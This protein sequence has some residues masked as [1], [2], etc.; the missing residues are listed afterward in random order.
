MDKK[1]H[2]ITGLPRSGSTLLVSILR[3][4]PR[5]SSSISDSLCP[6][7]RTTIDN[8]Q[9]GPGVKYEVPVERRRNIAKYLIN[10]FYHDIDKP[11]IFNTSRGWTLITNV[12]KDILP[13]SKLIVCVRDINWIL[14]SFE[15]AQ[16]RN[17]F[18]TS[19]VSGG[20]QGN[21]Y[22]RC[23]MLMEDNGVVGA[24][25]IGVKQ[26]IS[27][28]EKNL[29]F[30]LEYNELTKNPE[31]TIRS[32]YEFIGEPYFDHDF[33]NVEGS[34]DEYDTEIGIKLHTVRKKVQYIEREHI[35]PPDILDRYR[36]MEVWR[37][38]GR[39]QERK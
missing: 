27:G 39:N 38:P 26:A 14:D 21:V 1:Y 3:Q 2:F 36:N 31:K 17:P 24:P 16:R 10:G 35:I 34:W 8:C 30:L 7:V 19:S 13:E 15:L 12:I 29:L 11:V 20:H 18:S 6:L 22:T 9:K 33:D 5:F 23:K 28:P 25:Y 37:T 4:N 32:L